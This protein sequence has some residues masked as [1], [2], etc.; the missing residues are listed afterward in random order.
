MEFWYSNRGLNMQRLDEIQLCQS[1]FGQEV[2]PEYAVLQ[3]LLLLSFC[4]RPNQFRS[5]TPLNTSSTATPKPLRQPGLGQRS[6]FKPSQ[7]KAFY[8]LESG[9]GACNNVCK[10]FG[11]DVNGILLLIKSQ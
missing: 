6:L 2:V 7:S 10:D 9:L 4:H 5:Q 3:S 8:Y 1:M 11:K